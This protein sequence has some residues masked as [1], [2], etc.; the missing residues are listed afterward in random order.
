[1]GGFNYG[2]TESQSS[3]TPTDM[4]PG[5][6]QG[7][8]PDIA[9]FVKNLLGGGGGYQGPL[10]APMTSGQESAISNIT[11]QAND[12]TRKSYIQQVLSGRFLP[13]QPGANPFLDSAIQAAQR[14]VLQGL[15]T[16]LARTL[17]GRFALAG[18][19]TNRA[20]Q[21]AGGGGG[22]S[23]FD[24]AAGETVQGV[25][26]TLG[27]ISSTMSSQQYQQERDQQTKV[28]ALSQ[29]EIQGL[30][31]ALQAESLPQMIQ[32]MGVA[33]G[34]KQFNARMNSLLQALS[35]I[36]QPNIA[37]ASQSTSEGTQFG[38][39]ITAGQPPAPK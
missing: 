16:T 19:M 6:Y 7:L 17:P 27:D 36:A 22:S 9:G 31:T 13:G 10:V 39:Q 4:T 26:R 15:E 29:Q 1:M 12:P 8:R 30:N 3:S 28:A 23:A 33:E 21:S 38:G 34:I 32:Q 35:L 2:E 25:A 14:P 11:G 37:N 18:H 5:E 20:G 24:R